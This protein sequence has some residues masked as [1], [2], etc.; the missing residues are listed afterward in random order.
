MGKG[1]VW[2]SVIQ[3]IDDRV[4]FIYDPIP[5]WHHLWDAKNDKNVK[6]QL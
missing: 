3:N 2:V 4:V 6:I 1:K 5:Y